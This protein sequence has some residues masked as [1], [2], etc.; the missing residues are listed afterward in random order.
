MRAIILAI[1]MI[2]VPFSTIFSFEENNVLEDVQN[3]SFTSSEITRYNSFNTSYDSQLI[4]AGLDFEWVDYVY[5]ASSAQEPNVNHFKQR[6]D[7]S[8]LILVT[9][10]DSGQLLNN[11]TYLNLD[12]VLLHIDENGTLLNAK[13]IDGQGG[14]DTRKTGMTVIIESPDGNHLHLLGTYARNANGA[15]SIFNGTITIPA[16]PQ[17]NYP[18]DAFVALSLNSST[19]SY[20][21]HTVV[22]PSAHQYGHCEVSLY[23]DVYVNSTEFAFIIEL[24]DRHQNSNNAH[25]CYTYQFDNDVS[26]TASIGALGTGTS[27]NFI[28]RA[29]HSLDF[30]EATMVGSK[31]GSPSNSVSFQNAP[32]IFLSDGGGLTPIKFIKSPFK[33]L[34]SLPDPFTV[35]TS[36]LFSVIIFLTA[37]DNI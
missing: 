10:K 5:S 32:P 27:T 19:F 25:R 28:V 29:N 8:Y 2:L 26:I 23:E 7:G 20:I 14:S 18:R 37:G 6:L 33:T 3:K 34:P 24:R 30:I 35:L 22:N 13:V 1:I 11:L 16:P 17:Y 31:S 15:Y 36:I 4:A 21:D 12:S 9:T